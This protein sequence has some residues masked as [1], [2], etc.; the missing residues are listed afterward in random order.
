VA[1]LIS[2]GPGFATLIEQREIGRFRHP[3]SIH[4]QVRPIYRTTVC[5]LLGVV[6]RLPLFY[7]TTRLSNFC[8]K[9][10]DHLR[11]GCAA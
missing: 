9:R 2:Q 11:P 10:V 1:A 7:R 6:R 8:L 4:L 5:S 3:P